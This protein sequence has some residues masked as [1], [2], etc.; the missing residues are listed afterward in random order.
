MIMPNAALLGGK[1]I[2]GLVKRA[3]A[4]ASRMKQ[5]KS[6]PGHVH[7]SDSSGGKQENQN[8]IPI[9]PPPPSSEAL[10]GGRPEVGKNFMDA[11]IG[12]F[13]NLTDP[14]SVDR[15]G[16]AMDS[17]ALDPVGIEPAMNPSMATPTTENIDD[18]G[19]NSLYSK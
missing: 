5:D 8:E 7:G 1:N 12:N 14:L 13:S 10:S 17:S 15:G 2:E 3:G 9:L 16:R 11:D 4:E 6:K 19:V 18:T